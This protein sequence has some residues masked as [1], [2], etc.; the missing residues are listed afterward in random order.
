MRSVN[1]I[2]YCIDSLPRGGAETLLFL[3]CRELKKQ[4]HELQIHLAT[5]NDG[6]ELLDDF[7][8]L[9]IVFHPLRAREKPLLSR[10]VNYWK[11]IRNIS[12][13]VVH[14][15]LLYSDR[16]GLPA[17][18]FAGV[19][20]RFST[21]HN[22]ELHRGLQD[23]LTR[24]ITS[25]FATKIIAV[26][27]EAKRFSIEQKM[28]PENKIVVIWNAIDID[29][30][31][32]SPRN[33]KQYPSLIRMIS[34]GRVTEQKHQ[35][36][37]VEAFIILTQ[38]GWT[39]LLLDFYG[40]GDDLSMIAQRIEENGVRN[41]RL[42]G[43]VPNTKIASKLKTA[44]VYLSSSI[45]EGFGMAVLEAMSVG[46]P[47]IISDIPPHRELMGST[48][49]DDQCFFESRN[50]EKLANRIEFLLSDPHLYNQIAQRCYNRSSLFT[51]DLL[52]DKHEKLYEGESVSS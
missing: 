48:D 30:D 45:Y 46:L 5:C 39:N 26:S 34:I 4:N 32:Y 20:K 37:M 29:R 33:I 19:K 14:T 12:P 47:V 18:F 28:Y 25:I 44:D 52:V 42:C 43:V 11:L 6:G 3:I 41:V 16:Y 31:A 21:N 10:W 40:I 51:I 50:A 13:D 24:K 8:S 23:W 2:L 17:A 36:T 7:I 9:G 1:K 15:H 38:R 49:E 35:I 27:H 22:M